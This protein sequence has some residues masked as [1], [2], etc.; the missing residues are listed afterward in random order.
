[1]YMLKLVSYIKK[2]TEILLFSNRRYL[3]YFSIFLKHLKN[4]DT[5]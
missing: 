4:S 3:E 5:Q 1:M 2:V